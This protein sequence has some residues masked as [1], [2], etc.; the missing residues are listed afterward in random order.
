MRFV[1]VAALT[2]VSIAYGSGAL[3]LYE[4]ERWARH[5][6]SETGAA[7]LRHPEALLG[8]IR[9]AFASDNFSND[10]LPL[11]YAALEETPASYQS[12]FLLAAFHANRLEYPYRVR[13][14]FEAALAR[15]PANGRLHLTY[16]RWLLMSTSR[17]EETLPEAEQHIREAL[18]LE[19]ELTRAGIELL[20]ESELPAA[21]WVDLV[22]SDS[23]ARRELIPALLRAGRRKQALDLLS[24]EVEVCRDTSFL[25][26]AILWA[27]ESEA[28]ELAMHSARRW[29]E[30][31]LASS[32]IGRGYAQATQKVAQLLLRSG[33]LEGAYANVRDALDRLDEAQGA[34]LAAAELLCSMGYEYLQRGQEVMAESLFLEA[35]DRAPYYA[36]AVVGLARTYRKR[37]D[38]AAAV[39]QYRE[40]LL[41]DP[42][43]AEARRELAEVVLDIGR[44]R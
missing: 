20:I 39:A 37:Q 14:S 24:R 17:S 13:K 43:S 8:H 10:V 16:A 22:P 30:L 35:K 42:E 44:E 18:R 15:Y 5:P 12:A 26:Q 1:I 9:G 21:R 28:A 27:E 38:L 31:E 34:P 19:P 36:P 2:L 3:Y 11:L 40:A 25:R 41:L 7:R 33:D 29:R 6:S 23:Q 32:S 4:Q